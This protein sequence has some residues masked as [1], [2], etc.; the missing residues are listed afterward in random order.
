MSQDDFQ[1]KID[2]IYEKC[3]RAVGIVDDIQVFGSDQTHDLHLHEAMERTR[4]AGIKLNYDKCIFKSK[5]CSFFGNNYTTET[6]KPNPS[7]VDAIKRMEAPSTK[8]ELQSFLGMVNYLNSYM[9]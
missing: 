2:H 6:V 9:P 7:K 5:S 1:K 4:R 3:R 8:Q